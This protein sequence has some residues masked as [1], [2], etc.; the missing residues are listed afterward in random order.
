MLGVLL[1]VLFSPRRHFPQLAATPSTG[2][3]IALSS[4]WGIERALTRSLLPAPLDLPP[5]ARLLAGL[6]LGA[7]ASVGMTWLAADVIAWFTRRL[8]GEVTPPAMRTV[9]AWSATPRLLSIA[10]VAALIAV[11]GTQA[12]WVERRSLMQLP[13]IGPIVVF[14]QAAAAGWS[15]RLAVVGLSAVSG[16][17]IA[18]ALGAY[19]AAAVVLIAVILA[20]VAVW[21]LAF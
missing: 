12:V 20:A 16:L 10:A 3:V 17:S 8:G 13:P 21:Q 2:W 6:A 4:L 19:L 18:R 14:A 5:A 7:A 1:G 9:L 11:E 15:L